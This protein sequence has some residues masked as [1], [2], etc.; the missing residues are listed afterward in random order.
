MLVSLRHLPRFQ[1]DPQGGQRLRA[2]AASGLPGGDGVQKVLR[3]RKLPVV[4]H[5]AIREGRDSSRRLLQDDF[6]FQ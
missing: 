2:A 5:T 1:A 6:V 4:L 3:L